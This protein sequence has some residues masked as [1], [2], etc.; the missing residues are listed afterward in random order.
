MA[1]LTLSL[2]LVA[3]IG[4]AGGASRSLVEAADSQH[5]YFDALVARAEH[6]KSFSLRDP[7]QLT[8][9]KFGGYTNANSESV[10]LWVTYNP[11]A[12]TDGHKQDAAK[13]VIP[14]FDTRTRL[15][16]NVSSSD[17]VIVLED[18]G[19]GTVGLY[20]AGRPIRIGNEILTTVSRSGNNITVTRGTFGTV[21]APHSA[22]SNVMI[23]TN[24]LLNQLRLPLGTSDGH[25]YVFTWDTYWTDSYVN[26][27]LTSHKAFQLATDGDTRWIETRA[28]YRGGDSC[29]ELKG[30]FNG[31]ADVGVVDVRAYNDVG[32]AT[33]WTSA[34]SNKLGPLMTR[35]Q[36]LMPKA[37]GGPATFTIKPNTWTR[38]WIRV[39]Q[40][41]NNYD[42]FDLW[43][44]DEQRNPVR[45]YGPVPASIP[46][47]GSNMIQ[48]FWFEFNT[49]TDLFV[50]GD[51]RDLVSY[52]RNFVA[53]RDVSDIEPLLVKPG[54][55]LPGGPGA[56]RGV[57]IIRGS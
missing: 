48:K 43:V 16:S 25:T 1:R 38:F 11:T 20:F 28:R 15:V 31:T 13:V 27:G 5:G 19:S 57:R 29:C 50:R 18:A 33:S 22:G 52:I 47:K 3:A 26:S 51:Q 17:S 37:S 9:P 2:V 32:G 24:S 23:S 30:L 39:D 10:G 55:G 14:P 42:Y 12:D 21:P 45:L 56:V 6:W 7:A 49:S 4:I 53:L 54:P 46:V 34:D 40:R 44:A 35:D 36:P 41:A 8:Y